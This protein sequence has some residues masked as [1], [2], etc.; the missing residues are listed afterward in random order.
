M[1]GG[2]SKPIRVI[3]FSQV[4]AGP[5]CTRLLADVGAEVLK[6]EPPGGESMRTRQPMRDGYS[7]YFGTLNAGK[8]SVELDLKSEQGLRAAQALAAEADVLVENFRPGVMDRLG[9][10]W[11]ELSK[12]NPRLVYCSISGYG[13]EG[14]AA[15]RPAYAPM[16][17]AASGLDLAL[18]SYNPDATRPAPTAIFY[19]D[20]LAGIYAWGAIQTA[21]FER[22]RRGQGQRVD[23]A[24][25]DSL[26][27]LMVYECQAAQFAPEKPRHVYTPV[28]AKDGFVIVVP[29]SQKNFDGMVEILGRPAWAADPRF[30]TTAGREANWGE[31]TAHVEEWSQTRTAEEVERLFTQAGVPSSR[32]RSVAEVLRDPATIERGVMGDVR[33]GAGVFQVPNPPFRM[34]MTRSAVG[35]VIPEC[36]EATDEILAS[37][38]RPVE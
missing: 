2:G 16:M 38:K 9:L 21:L 6:I 23:V 35:G 27:S 17:H 24:L 32:Y 31:I 4:M 34:S 19:A 12:R 11:E 8:R 18:M 36:G 20:V 29:L 33:D 15:G 10:G 37:L 30:S 13:Q 3:D 22:E 5:F 28:R 26:L 7:T 25:M 1:T 14:Q